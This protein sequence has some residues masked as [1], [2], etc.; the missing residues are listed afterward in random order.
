MGTVF[1]VDFKKRSWVALTEDAPTDPMLSLERFRPTIPVAE[2]PYANLDMIQL[3]EESQRF[4]AL[5]ATKNGAIT[6]ELCRM[7][8]PIYEAMVYRAATP[9][10]RASAAHLA[11][12]LAEQLQAFPPDNGPRRA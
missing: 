4:Q 12:C 10:F 2:N 6:P 9:E 8:I 1:K 3:L 11:A 5:L 7:G